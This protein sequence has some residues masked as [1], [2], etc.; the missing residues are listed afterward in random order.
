[1]GVRIHSDAIVYL[2]AHEMYNDGIRFYISEA[3]KVVYTQGVEDH[4]ER[5]VQA[6][7]I[8]FIRN[9]RTGEKCM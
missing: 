1:M 3:N 8:L 4:G 9:V 5:L 7:Y 2:A 6:R